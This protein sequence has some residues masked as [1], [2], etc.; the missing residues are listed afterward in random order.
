MK[1]AKIIIYAKNIIQKFK[2]MVG[3]NVMTEKYMK[4]KYIKIKKPDFNEKHEL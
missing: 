2:W 3:V 1:N 4:T